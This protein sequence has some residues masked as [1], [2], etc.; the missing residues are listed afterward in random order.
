MSFNGWNLVTHV[1]YEVH[2]NGKPVNPVNYY[3]EDLTDE[4][5]ERLIDISST[6]LNSDYD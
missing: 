1:H 4:E 5:Y 6:E 2:K 3:F